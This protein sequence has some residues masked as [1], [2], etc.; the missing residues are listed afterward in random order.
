[1][2]SFLNWMSSK[3]LDQTVGKVIGGFRECLEL[4]NGISSDGCFHAYHTW[5]GAAGEN[6]KDQPVGVEIKKTYG[7]F[8]L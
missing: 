6:I 5:S 2:P 3:L 8:V 7:I 4:Y 1:M